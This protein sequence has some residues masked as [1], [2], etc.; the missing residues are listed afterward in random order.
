[1]TRSARLTDRIAE[2]GVG[3]LGRGAL[4]PFSSWVVHA[5]SSRKFVPRRSAH[6][7]LGIV[8]RSFCPTASS[9]FS[10]ARQSRRGP[11]PV[12]PPIEALP[13]SGVFDT[14]RGRRT[15]CSRRSTARTSMPV[16]STQAMD[17]RRPRFPSR[18]D[19]GA[20]QS[21]GKLIFHEKPRPIVPIMRSYPLAAISSRSGFGSVLRFPSSPW[22]S[23]HG[24]VLS[25]LQN[26]PRR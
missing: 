22:R 11:P 5:R 15:R 6:P 8:S 2:G 23:F 3:L 24:Y 4:G 10:R 9:G 17:A 1:M 19:R 25:C 21:A 18:R 16:A 7:S 13:S 12:H 14:V 20:V 26:L